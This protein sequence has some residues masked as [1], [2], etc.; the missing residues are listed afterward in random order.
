MR[1]HT[2]PVIQTLVINIIMIMSTNID[3][4]ILDKNEATRKDRA[5]DSDDDFEM[6]F[7]PHAVPARSQPAVHK[8]LQIEN[9]R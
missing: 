1:R 7:K 4:L 6:V 8:V 9:L 5:D 3:K 2:F